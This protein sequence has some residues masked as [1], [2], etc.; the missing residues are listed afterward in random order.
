MKKIIVMAA[1]ALCGG[2]AT[3]GR[4]SVVDWDSREASQIE[5][6]QYEAGVIFD[7]GKEKKETQRAGFAAWQELFDMITKLRVRI[8]VISVEWS[9]K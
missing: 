4:V 7:G 5:A 3:N 1:L 9:G 2:C 8:R 6:A